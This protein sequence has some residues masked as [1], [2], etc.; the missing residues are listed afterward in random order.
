MY[1][2]SQAEEISKQYTISICVQKIT[3]KD[4]NLKKSQVFIIALFLGMSDLAGCKAI[5]FL[6]RSEY[7]TQGLRCLS[8]HIPSC[9][10]ILIIFLCRKKTR[11]EVPMSHDSHNAVLNK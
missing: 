5:L 4:R 7:R 3:S 6:G 9:N 11:I 1:F 10:V 8:V 2:K